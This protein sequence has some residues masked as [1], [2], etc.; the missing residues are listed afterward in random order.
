MHTFF[1]SLPADV[2]EAVEKVA[3]VYLPEWWRRGYCC[4]MHVIA[5]MERIVGKF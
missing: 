3:A 4:P 2:R 5:S 1:D